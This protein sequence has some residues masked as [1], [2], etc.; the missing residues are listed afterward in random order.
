[1]IEMLARPAF[2]RDHLELAVEIEKLIARNR[3]GKQVFQKR[4]FA[5]TQDGGYEQVKNRIRELLSSA[6]LEAGE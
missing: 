1:M 2:L 4:Y 6:P 3:K 5:M